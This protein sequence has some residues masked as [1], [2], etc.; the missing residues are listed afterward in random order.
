MKPTNRYQWLQASR[1]FFSLPLLFTTVMPVDFSLEEKRILDY[2]CGNGRDAIEFAKLGAVVDCADILRENLQRAKETFFTSK[3]FSSEDNFIYLED[4]D[5]IP[6]E[7]ETYDII[8][9]SGVLHHIENIN[10]VIDEFWR[11]LKKGGL[12]YCM[13]YSEFLLEY[14]LPKLI[15]R[16]EKRWQERFGMLTDRCDYATFYTPEKAEELFKG[17]FKILEHKLYYNNYFRI[18]KL[19]KIK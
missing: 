13:L 14:H 15:M 19:Q 10:S 3:L 7:D 12:V 16:S 8:N 17:K 5:K 4:S 1:D 6:V 2:G 9:C 18:Y 11:V